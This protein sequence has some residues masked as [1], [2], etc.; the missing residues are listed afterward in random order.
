MKLKLALLLLSLLPGVAMAAGLDGSSMSLTWVIPFA[1][2]L[3]S[4]ALFPIFAPHFWH[5]N[6]GKIAAFWGAL[7]VLPFALY[8]GVGPT[9]G[10]IAHAIL[11]EYIP[12]I[13]ILFALYT[14]SGGILVWGNLHGS[15]KLNTGILALGT[16]LASVMGTTG[17]A[18]L[19]IRPI[20]KANDNRVHNV[21]VVV[22]FIFLVANVGGGLTP[23]GD[24]PLFLGFLKGVD[25][26]WT[27]EHMAAPVLLMSVLLLAMFYAIDS[28]YFNKEGVLPRDKTPDSALKIYGKR[29]FFLLGGIIALVVMSGIWKPG[30]SFEVLGS[31]LQLQNLVRDFGL[32]LI[33]LLSLKIT[34]APVRAGNDFNWGPILEVA[35]LFAGIFIAMAPA[36][37]ILRAGTDGAMGGLVALVSNPDGTPH[38]AMYF[39][40]T[41]LLSAFLDNAPTYLVFFNLAHGDAAHMMGPYAST[42][43][44]ISC[45]AVFMGAMSYIGNAPNFM[46]KAVAEDRGIKMPSFFGYMAWSV[47]LLLP[48]CVIMTMVFFHY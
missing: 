11:E 19:L 46:V 12:F 45:G 47:C 27:V 7:F 36:I 26:M 9:T 31:H 40:M 42:L 44:A 16:V 29:N 39:W 35:K 3:L 4:I 10:V 13:L 25:F 15:P 43:L 41:G 34:P 1:G 37:A 22:F 8:A 48:V 5:E 14:V 17:A 28:Y 32:L 2:L 38:D 20:L 33:G 24:P 21:H 30:V 23:L 18:M 6:F